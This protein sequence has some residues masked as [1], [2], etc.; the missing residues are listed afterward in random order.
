MKIVLIICNLY[1]CR[2]GISVV[3]GNAISWRNDKYYSFVESID[4]LRMNGLGKTSISLVCEEKA[5]AV[6][7]N[8][9]LFSYGLVYIINITRIN[10]ADI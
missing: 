1:V 10:E 8:N 7:H 2:I 6:L 3:L 9:S 4:L 5:I